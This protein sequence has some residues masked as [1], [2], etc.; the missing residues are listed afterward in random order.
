MRVR[1]VL[2]PLAVAATLAT[3]AT[4]AGAATAEDGHGPS[5][6]NRSTS[7]ISFVQITEWDH[8][9]AGT[10]D[11]FID[12][13]QHDGYE[14]LKNDPQ[15]Q[16]FRVV[17]DPDHPDRLTVAELFANQQAYQAH[18]QGRFQ[19]DLLAAAK[20]DGV[21]GPTTLV[22]NYNIPA[23]KDGEHFSTSQGD[24]GKV[25]TV[26]ATFTNVQPSCRDEFIKI[27]QADGVDSLAVE[28]GTLSFAATPDPAD[29]T[30]FVFLET[31]TGLDAFVAHKNDY[32]AQRYLAVV[33]KC[34]IVGPDFGITN[35]QV[36]F[37]H[38]GGW[39]VPNAKH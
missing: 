6:P 3:G 7:P 37:D 35:S 33:A 11:A 38:P 15:V 16:D 29:P 22:A 32:P 14:S 39:S 31:F 20:K 36:G 4:T 17:P 5:E 2:L 21:S 12:A 27:A 28:P 13:A 19:Q 23:T 18:Q 30:R 34:G 24:N 1:N 25:F 26:V 9:P 10:R 8:I